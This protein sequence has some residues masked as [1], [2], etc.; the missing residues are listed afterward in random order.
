MIEE[1]ISAWTFLPKENSKPLYVQH[2]GLEETEQNLDYFGNK[3]TWALSEPLMATV[4]L[5]LSNVTKGGEILFPDSESKSETWSDCT[6]TSNIQKPVKGNAV[7]FFTTH[8]NGSPDS[9]SPHARCPVLEGEMWFATKFF[10]LRAVTGETISF[11][12]SRNECSDEDPSCPEWAAVG[13]CQRNPVFMVGSPDYYG[14]CRK[15][16]NAC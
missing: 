13:E 10:Y 11:D 9:S 7:L 6:K 15:S 5:Y 2:Y 8:L 14:T 4:I 16:C 3:S 1:R 12:S